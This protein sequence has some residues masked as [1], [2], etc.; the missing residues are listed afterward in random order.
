MKLFLAELTLTV[1][2]AAEDENEAYW[3]TR[4]DIYDIVENE[5]TD[6]YDILIREA[7]TVPRDWEDA[8]PYGENP[9]E[10]TCNQILN[11]DI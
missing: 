2:V 4:E 10:L 9:D 7:T 8:L 6:T 5:L 11:G 3:K 1:V